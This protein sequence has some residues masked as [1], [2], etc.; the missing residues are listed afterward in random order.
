MSEAPTID[1]TGTARARIRELEAALAAERERHAELE[2]NHDR[3]VGAYDALVRQIELMRR[4]LFVAKAARIDTTQLELEFAAKLAALDAL[5][6]SPAPGDAGQGA[7]PARKKRSPSGRRDLGKAD[8]P[9]ERMEV[10]DVELEGKLPRLGSEEENSTIMWRRAGW[11]RLVIARIKYRNVDDEVPCSP[12]GASEMSVGDDTTDL[13]AMSKIITARMPPQIIP[14]SI[15]APSMFAHLITE[16]L[17]DGIPYH[18]QQERLARIGLSLDRGTMC[19][20]QEQIGGTVGATVVEAMRREAMST[21]FWLGTDATGILVQPIRTADKQRRACRRGHYFVQI[22]DADHVFFE[23]TL[24]K[25][26]QPSARCSRGSL[27]TSR[28]TPRAFTTSCSVRPTSACSP[29]MASP[30]SGFATRSGV[31]AMPGASSGRPQSPARI[32][33]RARGSRASP[34]S[35]RSTGPGRT[36]GTPRSNRC[37]SSTSDRTPMV[38]SRSLP[39][40]TSAS[41]TSAACCA[42]PWVTPFVSKVRSPGSSTTA[43]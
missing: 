7:G 33:S 25:P 20:W 38:F 34:A 42:P 36:G 15:G 22:A 5:A 30:T 37:A 16:K 27:G 1:E 23:Y 35:S 28:R 8:A 29:T 4:R 3:L 11:V 17:C 9:V 43:G 19:R 24:T 18:R 14:K 41:R 31:G 32:R 26:A 40:S 12:A 10:P 13:A 2:R 39:P 6:G 21:A